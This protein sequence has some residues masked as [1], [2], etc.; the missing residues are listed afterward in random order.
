MQFKLLSDSSLLSLSDQIE[1]EFFR[2]SV[3]S[4]AI[5]FRNGTLVR[6]C[7]TQSEMIRAFDVCSDN[8][9]K[10]AKTKA[11]RKL[12]QNKYPKKVPMSESPSF[13][14]VAVVSDDNTIG[15]AF[16]RGRDLFKHVS[17][18]IHIFS[19]LKL[20]INISIS[21]VGHFF[22]DSLHCA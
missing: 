7:R 4:E 12:P 18:R 22:Q 15:L 3:I 14:S 2:D 9:N 6:R 10:F 20:E 16:E 1:C 21:N 17:P 8:I 11:T 13:C 5:G 19:N